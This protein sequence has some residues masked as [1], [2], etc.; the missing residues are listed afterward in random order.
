MKSDELSETDEGGGRARIRWP[1]YDGR[2]PELLERMCLGDWKSLDFM[3]RFWE[4][5]YDE[6]DLLQW[7]RLAAAWR[8]RASGKSF[9]NIPR[10]SFVKIILNYR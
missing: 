4:S 3:S 5:V 2:E 7:K 6:R 8:L 1:L 10:G 9:N